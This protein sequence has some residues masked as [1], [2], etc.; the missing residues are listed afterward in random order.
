MVLHNFCSMNVTNCTDGNMSVAGLIR[1]GAGNLYGTTSFG[2]KNNTANAGVGGG[3]VFKVDATNHET[4]LYSFCSTGGANCTDGNQPEAGLFEDS[5]GNLYG[6]TVYGGANTSANGGNGGGTVFRL[7]TSG[8]ETVLYSFCSAGGATCTDGNMP[9]AGLI[10]DGAGNLYST[11]SQGGTNNIGKGGGGTVF[12]LLA[13]AGEAATITLTS[14]LN[15]SFVNQSVTFSVMVSGSGTTPTGSVTFE[16]GSTVLGTETLVNGQASFT[17]TIKKSGNVSIVASYSGDQ[18]YKAAN[19][20]PL[21]QVVDKPFTTSTAL[22][23]SLNPSTYGQ[24]VGLTATVS[25]AGPTPTGTV[26]FRNGSASLGSATLSGGVAK[27]TT[28][29]LPAGTLTLTATYGGNTANAKSVSSGLTQVVNQANSKTSI[30]SSVNP[31]NAGQTVKFT[32]TVTSATTT[33]T[34]TVKFNDGSTELG[35]GTLAK[36][37]ASFST[38]TLSAGSHKITAVYEGTANTVGGTSP[39]LT[40]T[41]N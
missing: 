17:V 29:K 21:T 1:D 13:S 10:R 30:V 9:V 14:S 36:G 41:V 39:A 8:I 25:S 33:P 27:I 5:A 37:K 4:V 34:G 23:S 6:T 16:E 35:T 19:S 31:S 18:N 40:Q 38:S 12:K 22:A 7:D 2:G 3:T 26:T 24:A 11:T 15:P 20:S 32:A 28:S